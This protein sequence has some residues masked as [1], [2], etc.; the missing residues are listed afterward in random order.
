[1]EPLDNLLRVFRWTFLAPDVGAGSG[2]GDGQGGGDNPG[3]EGG[4]AEAPAAGTDAGPTT[5]SEGEGEPSGGDEVFRLEDV[6]D[7]VR[8]HAERLQRQM[9]A[10]LSRA[11]AQDREEFAAQREAIQMW[12]RLNDPDQAGEALEELADRLGYEPAG[13]R[14]VAEAAQNGS[15][16]ESTELELPP[17]LQEKLARVDQLSEAEQKRVHNERVRIVREHVEEGVKQLAGDD[18]EVPVNAGELARYAALAIRREDGLPGVDR[19]VELIRA[20]EADAVSRYVEELKRRAENPSADASG[21]TGV[22]QVDTSTV[23]G[24]LAASERIAQRHLA[25]QT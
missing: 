1:M 6:P 7:E 10:T 25:T 16:G 15:G 4:E 23:E 11:R 22:S 2:G 21:G 13:A 24:R 5:G 8:P 20:V 18:G 9:Q 17:E 19:A 3:S 14:Q 12:E